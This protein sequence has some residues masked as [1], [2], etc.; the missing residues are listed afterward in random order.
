[1]KGDLIE[2]VIKLTL[3]VLGHAQHGH[4]DKVVLLCKGTFT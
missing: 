4:Y 1:M 2:E 3:A